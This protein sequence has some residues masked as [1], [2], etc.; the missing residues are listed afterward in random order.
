MP[1]PSDYIQR[2]AQPARVESNKIEIQPSPSPQHQHINAY[3]LQSTSN[4]EEVPHPST[5][6]ISHNAWESNTLAS[7]QNNNNAYQYTG[8]PYG[9]KD[10]S[11]TEN[12]Y[13]PAIPPRPL[14]TSN[15]EQ[16]TQQ[17][18]KKK[19]WKSKTKDENGVPI[20]WDDKRM[21]PS[22]LR[23]LLR[24]I[25][26]IAS[27]GHLGFAAGASP[28]SGEGVPFY[29]AACFYYLFAVAILTIFWTLYHI[30]YFCFRRFAKGTKMN[31]PFMI[32]TDTLFAILWGIGMIVEVAKFNC[33]PG[34]YNGWCHF[35]NVSIFWGFV[36]FASFIGAAVWDGVGGCITHKR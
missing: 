7:S 23:L 18:N 27:V 8:T 4:K 15:Q 12:A 17:A 25:Q 33:P 21:H 1:S 34:E 6:P 19:W 22:K 32:A 29:T 11:P 16:G 20:E 36:C 2:P 14:S 30:G 3:E 13:S 24:F 31:R 9:N 35:Y 28:F 5:T 10:T 26:F